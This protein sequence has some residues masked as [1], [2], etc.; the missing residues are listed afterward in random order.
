MTYGHQNIRKWCKS[1]R[2][3]KNQQGHFGK[4]AGEMSF[5]SHLAVVEFCLDIIV[6]FGFRLFTSHNGRTIDNVKSHN[7]MK[8]N[9]LFKLKIV[10]LLFISAV[11]GEMIISNP[12]IFFINFATFLY[13][14]F[15]LCTES[16]AL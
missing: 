9:I 3:F 2:A 16:K 15:F 12:Y 7:T 6:V 5:R 14:S 8:H 13:T 10:A 4:R 1:E 11:N